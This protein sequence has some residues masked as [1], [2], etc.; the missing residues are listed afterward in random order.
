MQRVAE[1]QHEGGAHVVDFGVGLVGEREDDGPEKPAA[2]G[3][4][5]GDGVGEGV[6]VRF[7]NSGRVVL[8]FFSS[9]AW[10]KWE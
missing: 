7:D 4:D 10:V 2:D 6:R 5:E 1:A 9:L 8:V 3:D